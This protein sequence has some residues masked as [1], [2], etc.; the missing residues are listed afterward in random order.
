MNWLSSDIKS[1]DQTINNTVYNNLGTS[2]GIDLRLEVQG[3]L[4]GTLFNTLPKGHWVILRKY[5]RTNY[6]ENFLKS[7]KE[8]VGGSAFEYTDS[9]VRTRYTDAS[10]KRDTF[11]FVKPGVV[12][13]NNLVYYFDYTVKP[14][15]GDYIMELR[16][17][18]H[19][20]TPDINIVETSSR[21]LIKRVHP[22][23]ID[24]G[25][26]AYYACVTER[27]LVRYS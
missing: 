15:E 18:D 19:T 27:D 8:G 12:P 5:D 2:E 9:L 21:W 17:D 22:Y 10:S 6:S 25:N 14:N 13:D 16:H 4:Y 1:I 20:I 23:R 26:I 3:I 11:D 24:N 7:T